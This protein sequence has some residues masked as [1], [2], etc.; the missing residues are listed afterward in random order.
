MERPIW[1]MQTK[2]AFSWSVALVLRFREA[3]SC[4]VAFVL[5]FAK[6]LPCF[7]GYYLSDDDRSPERSH[8]LLAT[9][10][11]TTIVPRW[12]RWTDG[13]GNIRRIPCTPLVGAGG[14]MEVKKSVVFPAHSPGLDQ[15]DRGRRESV[16]FP[17]HSPGLDP[18]D[19]GR[20]TS[21]GSQTS[22]RSCSTPQLK[23]ANQNS[24]PFTCHFRLSK[25]LLSLLVWRV[26]GCWFCSRT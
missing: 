16:V 13:G 1:N 26:A 20:L 12:T 24:H 22:R 21:Q 7:A 25:A 17:A 19:R 4:S 3:L 2:K 14:P 11:A 23:L 9:I 8:A 10:S 15:A 18:V 5:R 6:T